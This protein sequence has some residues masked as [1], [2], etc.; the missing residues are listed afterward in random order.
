MR[1]RKRRRRQCFISEIQAS[2][3]QSPNQR[4]ESWHFIW[5]LQIQDSE[6]EGEQECSKRKTMWCMTVVPTSA[7]YPRKTRSRLFCRC[8][9]LAHRNFPCGRQRETIPTWKGEEEKCICLAHSHFLSA[10]VQSPLH[11]ELTPL[12]FRVASKAFFNI[13]YG[14]SDLVPWIWSRGT[15]E[16]VEHKGKE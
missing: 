7:W 8:I 15:A 4:V 11:R 10:T 13:R 5:P 6:D 12:H 16:W 2:R 1:R 3:Q 14:M 9:H